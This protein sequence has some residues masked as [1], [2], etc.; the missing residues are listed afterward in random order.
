M[1]SFAVCES[2]SRVTSAT[3]VLTMAVAFATAANT[4]VSIIKVGVTSW[5]ASVKTD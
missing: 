5:A 3:T 4:A 2:G 1:T